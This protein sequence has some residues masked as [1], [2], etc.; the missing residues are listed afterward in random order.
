MTQ[1]LLLLVVVANSKR[2]LHNMRLQYLS[3][4]CDYY[5]SIIQGLLALQ[6]EGKNATTSSLTQKH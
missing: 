2:L 3:S 6:N 5:F 4:N 1:I